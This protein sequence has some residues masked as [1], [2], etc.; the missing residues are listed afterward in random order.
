[1]RILHLVILMAGEC[2]VP[3][4]LIASISS[5]VTLPPVWSYSLQRASTT[6]T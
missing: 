1:M 2:S 4:N 6:S 5:G 3:Q